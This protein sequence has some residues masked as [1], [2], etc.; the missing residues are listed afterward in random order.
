MK[1][2]GSLPGGMKIV[3]ISSIYLSIPPK[4]HER[5]ERIVFDLCQHLPKRGHQVEAF[6]WGDSKR[7][8]FGG[9]LG[10]AGT[11]SL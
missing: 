8:P 4:T 10:H 2:S 3:A 6:A 9:N 7:A 5:T 11:V 1:E